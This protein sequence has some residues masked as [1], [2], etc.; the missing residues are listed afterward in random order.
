MLSLACLR[1]VSLVMAVKQK[2]SDS[3]T[4]PD[5]APNRTFMDWT[6]AEQGLRNRFTDNIQNALSNGQLVHDQAAIP[7][8]YTITRDVA[9]P[10]IE[11]N[12]E[13]TN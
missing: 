8:I 4:T 12:K 10:A 3:G 1:D 11:F 7:F 5:N 6:S 9:T 2:S 13:W